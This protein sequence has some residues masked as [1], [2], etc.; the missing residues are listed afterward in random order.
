MDTSL[1]LFEQL[2][3]DENEIGQEDRSFTRSGLIAVRI[4]SPGD[5]AGTLTFLQDNLT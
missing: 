5:T 1:V 4:N 3:Y 2:E